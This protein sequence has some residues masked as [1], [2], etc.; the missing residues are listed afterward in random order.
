MRR[1]EGRAQCPAPSRGQAID[2]TRNGFR[3]AA[4]VWSGSQALLA[5]V[6]SLIRGAVVLHKARAVVG[7]M[8]VG[9]DHS[10]GGNR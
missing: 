3:S 5:V 6:E 10:L 9:D 1:N 2:F 4:R 7:D 8:D